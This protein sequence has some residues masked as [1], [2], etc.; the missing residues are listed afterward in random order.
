MLFFVVEARTR[1]G[2]HGVVV[3]AACWT[4]HVYN[5]LQRTPPSITEAL[6]VNMMALV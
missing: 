5:E 1:F 6:W 4:F 3:L 2:T